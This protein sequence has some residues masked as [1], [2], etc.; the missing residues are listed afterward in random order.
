MCRRGSILHSNGMHIALRPYVTTGIAIVGASVIAVAPVTV[1][2]PELPSVDADAVRSVTAD[3]ELTALVD[4][5]AAFPQAAAQIVQVVLQAVPLPAELESLVLALANAGVPAVTETFKLF[6]ETIPTTALNL[7]ATGKF[8]H[9]PVLAVQAVILGVV[10]PPAQYLS[11][12]VQE[13]P[14]PFG[15]PDGLIDESFKLLVQTPTLAG[16]TILNLLADVIDSGLSPVA[17]LS[18]MIDAISTAVTSALESVGKIVAALGG[19]LPIADLAPPEPM[20]QTRTTAVAADMPTADDANVLASNVNSSTQQEA[21]DAVTVAVDQ[22]ASQDSPDTNTPPVTTKSE[23][24][25]QELAGEDVTANGATDLSDGNMAESGIANDESANEQGDGSTTVAE[26]DT[27]V[28][29]ASGD[30]T[31]TTSNESAGSDEGSGDDG[32][33]SGE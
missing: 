14:L 31:A 29:G 10:T 11:A 2:P 16:I 18:G 5:I 15:T 24:E 22:S 32:E 6:T 23:N 4:L 20:D 7:V 21:V 19:A 28:E 27:T 25:P 3:V 8:A 33:S 17:A 9:I 26:E 13:L 12:L 1:P 30:Q